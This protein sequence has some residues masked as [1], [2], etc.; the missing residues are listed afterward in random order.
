MASS[1][2]RKYEEI[3][4]NYDDGDNDVEV[5][6][7]EED[8]GAS[9]DDNT[10]GQHLHVPD[11]KQRRLSQSQHSLGEEDTSRVIVHIDVDCF[12]A[13]VE[14]IRDP[15]LRDKPLG[16]QQKYIVVT[17]NYV[18]R[19][20][21]V[22]KLMGIKQAKELC[23]E[24]VLVKGEDLTHYR[25]MSYKITEALQKFSPLVERLGFDENFIDVTEAVNA[26]VMSSSSPQLNGHTFPEIETEDDLLKDERHT[27]LVCGSQIAGEMRET[28]HSELGITCCAGIAHNKLLAKLV[29]GRHKPN[30]QTTLLPEGVQPL[31][32]TLKTVRNIPGIGSRTFKR[33]QTLGISTV[34]D[35]QDAP[36]GVLQ[37]E[38]GP[39]TAQVMQQLCCGVDPSPVTPTG[40][41]QTISDEDSFKKCG[42]LQNAKERMTGLLQSL[43]KRLKGDGRIPHVLRVTVRKL[44]STNK[45]T[46][47][48]SRQSAIPSH[49]FGTGGDDNKDKETISKLLDLCVMLFCKM[50][51]VSHPFHLTLIN[52]CFA[53]LETRSKQS[54]SIKSFFQNE[55]SSTQTLQKSP[56]LKKASEQSQTPQGKSSRSSIESFFSRPQQ[57][58]SSFSEARNK[59]CVTSMADHTP[60]TT[61]S[62]EN[63][64]ATPSTSLKSFFMAK[65]KDGQNNSV[66]TD[67]ATESCHNDH[68]PCSNL[69][70]SSLIRTFTTFQYHGHSHGVSFAQETEHNPLSRVRTLP[71]GVDPEVFSELPPEIQKEIYAFSYQ[72]SGDVDRNPSTSQ[73][74]DHRI[75]NTE[76]PCSSENLSQIECQGSEEV[77]ETVSKVVNTESV[78]ED[79]VLPSGIDPAVFSELPREMRVELLNSWQRNNTSTDST[80]KERRP[81]AKKTG[82]SPSIAQ[83][84]KKTDS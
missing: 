17:C 24:L 18:A 30:Q 61:T 5:E 56:T 44:S 76:T 19:K 82:K 45:W 33:L 52:I 32:G 29:A 20:R 38:F 49:L 83:Y 12:Y 80:Q 27:R 55:P 34:Q 69:N 43:M 1:W 39:Q 62:Q 21:G 15:S 68:V 8:W 13:Q 71:S 77:E 79:I 10:Q 59:S 73:S 64:E 31:M 3:D 81:Q 7:A 60:Y 72:G 42:S 51:D 63:T 74:I 23:P 25:E 11:K 26:R 6:D 67:F 50:V 36:A 35:L 16:I 2:K 14:M 41:P 70:D 46:N 54:T 78:A 84:F 37:T 53:K 28:L 66:G 40:P 75:L 22:T 57:R 9:M 47:R 65:N 48:E 4:D 58:S